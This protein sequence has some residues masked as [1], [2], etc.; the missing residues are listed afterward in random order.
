MLLC[1]ESRKRWKQR[2]F[3]EFMSH[4]DGLAYVYSLSINAQTEQQH[5]S[6]CTHSLLLF[7]SL[8]ESIQERV[9]T[10]P[11]R[12]N[13]FIVFAIMISF[14]RKNRACQYL[15]TY[16]IPHSKS[17]MEMKLQAWAPLAIPVLKWMHW[18]RREMKTNL[19]FNTFY[20]FISQWSESFLPLHDTIEKDRLDGVTNRLSVCLLVIKRSSLKKTVTLWSVYCSQLL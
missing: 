11:T 1:S 5:G 15:T 17:R 20:L 9:Y 4:T 2:Q 12:G 3:S 14:D 10:S 13:E 8:H 18:R 19:Q 7:L 16:F 6:G